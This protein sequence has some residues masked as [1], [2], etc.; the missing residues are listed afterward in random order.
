MGILI[1]ALSQLTNSLIDAG[2][3][4]LDNYVTREFQEGRDENAF[5]AIDAWENQVA[6]N[7]GLANKVAAGTYNMPGMDLAGGAGQGILPTGVD[8][9]SLMQSFSNV[10]PVPPEIAKSNAAFQIFNQRYS[11]VLEN[12]PANIQRE[13][14]RKAQ[15]NRLG[16][17]KEMAGTGFQQNQMGWGETLGAYDNPNAYNLPREERLNR[18]GQREGALTTGRMAAQEPFKEIAMQ[19]SMQLKQTPGAKAI[20]TGAGDTTTGGPVSTV[21]VGEIG[22]FE[23]M[24]SGNKDYSYVDAATGKKVLNDRGMD[25]MNRASE[26]LGTMKKKNP[27]L[28]YKKAVDAEKAELNALPVEERM[29]RMGR[30]RL[31]VN[32]QTP[33]DTGKPTKEELQRRQRGASMSMPGE[34]AYNRTVVPQSQPRQVQPAPSQA[35]PAEIQRPAQ[36]QGQSLTPAQINTLDAQMKNA[37]PIDKQRLREKLKARGIN[38]NLIP[39]LR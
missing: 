33:T 13:I 38:P 17:V 29:Q 25:V 18:L 7:Y 19:R 9:Q 1:S 26:I 30:P 39:S 10:P 36:P 12:N 20:G 21:T 27:L 8:E 28:A 24:L 31:G 35:T 15:E 32:V 22:R 6:Q 5:R 4:Q 14:Q 16:L 11:D 3:N 23:K 2:I 37:D 34:S